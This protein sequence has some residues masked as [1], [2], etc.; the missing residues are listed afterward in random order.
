MS[1]WMKTLNCGRIYFDSKVDN[2]LFS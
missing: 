2:Q 1:L